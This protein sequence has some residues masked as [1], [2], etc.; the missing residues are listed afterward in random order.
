MTTKTP[1]IAHELPDSP[2]EL[3]PEEILQHQVYNLLL[4]PILGGTV[5][6]WLTTKQLADCLNTDTELVH[7]ALLDLEANGDVLAHAGPTLWE[8]LE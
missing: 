4:V 8:G 6:P 3:T 5:L 1:P 2:Q 7:E